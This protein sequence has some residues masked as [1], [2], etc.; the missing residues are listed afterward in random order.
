MHET[1]LE[2][3]IALGVFAASSTGLGLGRLPGFRV[4]RTRVAIIGGALMVLT[5]VLP[6]NDAVLA[7]LTRARLAGSRSCASVRDDGPRSPGHRGACGSDATGGDRRGLSS[8]RR[9]PDRSA[10]R[11]PAPVTAAARDRVDRGLSSLAGRQIALAEVISEG[12]VSQP[13]ISSVKTSSSQAL[14]M[15]PSRRVRSS[16]SDSLR[17]RTRA[18]II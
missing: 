4:D 6:W 12:E 16:S 5:G 17:R 3:T 14:S 7:V 8:R 15:A 18:A 10:S 13:L 1:T 11:P 2:R 9:P